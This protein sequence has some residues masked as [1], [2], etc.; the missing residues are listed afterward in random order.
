VGHRLFI[1]VWPPEEA[2]DSIARLERPQI[3]GLRWT[4]REQWHVTLR[5]L[6][7][8]TVVGE[9]VEAMA[10]LTGGGAR[11]ARAVMGPAVG[12]FGRRILHVPVAGLES[13]AAAVVAATETLGQRPD[14][15][16]F[17]GHITLARVAKGASVDLRALAGGLL[18]VQWDVD[19]VDLV[20]SRL[21]TSGARYEVLARFPLAGRAYL[22]GAEADSSA[23]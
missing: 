18:S 2:L 1:A 10:G 22:V 16:P 23:P 21:S 12:R 8:V 5:F 4:I 15:R 20:E 9:V 13:V 11:R 19:S 3:A 7:P 14:D 17:T 6:G